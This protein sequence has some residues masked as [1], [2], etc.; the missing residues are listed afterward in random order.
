MISKFIK[1]KQIV[2]KKNYPK[3]MNNILQS[4]FKIRPFNYKYKIKS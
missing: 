3:K 1:K 2:I 4:A